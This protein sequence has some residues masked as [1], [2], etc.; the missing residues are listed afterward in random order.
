VHLLLALLQH[1][2]RLRRWQEYVYLFYVRMRRSV[3]FQRGTVVLRLGFAD[4][5]FR[6]YLIAAWI[7]LS[8]LIESIVISFYH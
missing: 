6:F 3:L 2:L 5:A 7:Q 4:E 8:A 1:P